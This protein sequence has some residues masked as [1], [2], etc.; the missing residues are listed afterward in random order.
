VAGS[1]PRWGTHTR[2]YALPHARWRGGLALLTVVL[3]HALL[4]WLWPG[5]AL[6]P[7]RSARPMAPPRVSL[8][9]IAM[10]PSP[11]PQ[12]MPE[13]PSARSTLP[14]P[15]A[16]D[17]R[18]RLRPVAG[19][20]RPAAITAASAVPAGAAIAAIAAPAAE[21]APRA[22]TPASAPVSEP[23]LLDTAASRRAIRA[24]ARTA[25]LSTQAVAAS[26]EPRPAGAQERL[27]TAVK[28]AGQGDCLKGEY[29]GAG[30]GLLSLP[31]IAAAAA[32][33]ACAQ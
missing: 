29:I 12:R 7:A 18:A 3:L 6:V 28:S 25:S 23:S 32:R 15:V 14:R 19:T 1:T 13:A 26:E 33:G 24:S 8:R 17:S 30:M 22:E 27:G 11:S 5:A 2:T 31:F 16:A 4:V 21:A 20:T 9:L 10:Q